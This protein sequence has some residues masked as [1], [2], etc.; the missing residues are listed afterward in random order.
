[1][2]SPQR[3]GRSCS[4]VEGTGDQGLVG[5]DPDGGGAWGPGELVP[6]GDE[7]GG[8]RPREQSPV[9]QT[10]TWFC[11]QGN[12]KSLEGFRQSKTMI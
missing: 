5:L 12:E 2:E 10:G 1:M 3:G 7:G 11:L 9:H 6:A 4:W 8:G